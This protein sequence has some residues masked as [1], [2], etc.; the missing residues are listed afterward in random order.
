VEIVV[1]AKER[2]PRRTVERTAEPELSRTEREILAAIR[3][4]RFGSVE[5]VVHDSRVV[6]IERREKLRIEGEN[7]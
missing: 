7:A 1:R 4:L 2:D 3:G 6:R 5:I